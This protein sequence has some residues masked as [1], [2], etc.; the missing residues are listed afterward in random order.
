MLFRSV[1]R[2]AGVPG[3]IVQGRYDM[4]CPLVTA[5]ELAAAW[6]QATYRIVPDAGHS[7]WEPGIL[8]TL[9]GATE[10]FKRTGGFA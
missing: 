2:L 10:T 8:S 4:V 7:V 9:V 1:G 5:H 3:I 6:P